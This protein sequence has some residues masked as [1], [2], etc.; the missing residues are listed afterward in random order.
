[1]VVSD[2]RT[3]HFTGYCLKT[4]DEHLLT[5]PK[6]KVTLM[7]SGSVHML[8]LLM[9]IALMAD[10]MQSWNKTKTYLTT[11]GLKYNVCQD[12]HKNLE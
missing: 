8:A 9:S 11:R 7:Q 10:S 12:L 2:T 1:M 5:S 3:V 4:L 6:I